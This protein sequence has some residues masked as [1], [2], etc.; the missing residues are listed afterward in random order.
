M[1]ARQEAMAGLAK[2]LAIIEAFDANH[3]RLTLAEAARLTGLTRATARRCLLTLVELGY[4]SHD[5]KFFQP[6]P[7]LVHLGYAYLGADPLPQTAQPILAN[8]RDRAGESV[9]LAILDG[10]DVLFVARST[11]S[12]IVSTGVSL[13]ARMPAHCL[14]TGR[15]LL[16]AMPAAALEAYFARARF[17]R[18]TAKTLIER[19]SILAAIDRAGAEG[20][21][22]NDEEL[23]IGF[24][25]MAVPVR[26]A[27]GATVAAMSISTLSAR[28]SPQTMIDEFLP[29]L[30][31]GAV[32][33]G[34][35]LGHETPATTRQQAPTGH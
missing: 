32:M 29:L 15:V 27:G 34:R 24:R 11:V 31:Q 33:L 16:A 9:S 5:G 22:L 26:G 2:G 12:R 21:S 6:A 30:R 28:R 23:E 13:G 7:R 1:P 17:E 20:Y 8:I 25:S 18:R 10:D 35:A 3:P 14:A 4:L 19:A